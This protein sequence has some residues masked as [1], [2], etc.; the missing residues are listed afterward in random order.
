MKKIK[1]IVRVGFLLLF[2]SVLI[3]SCSRDGV[4]GRDGFDGFD[5]RDGRDGRDGIASVIS[6]T[7]FVGTTG[8]T[9]TSFGSEV[10]FFNNA[11]TAGVVRDGLVQA[12]FSLDAN[13]ETRRW[14]ALPYYDYG[15]SYLENFV[16]FEVYDATGSPDDLWY[17]VVVIPASAK[18]SGVDLNDFEAVTAI[19]GIE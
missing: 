5:G 13:P 19:Y 8:W 12:Y 1:K 18:V 17:K 14:I 4:D 6:E 15:Y 16:T 9:Q 11:I 3:I 10:N 7:Y 2:G